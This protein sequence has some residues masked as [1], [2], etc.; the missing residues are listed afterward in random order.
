MLVHVPKRTPSSAR[1]YP[2]RLSD[3]TRERLFAKAERAG[4]SLAEALRV[5]GEQY[6]DA[7]IAAQD[8][9]STPLYHNTDT[10]LTEVRS[11]AAK[12]DRRFRD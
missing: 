2:L 9:P 8:S 10:L 11:L 1:N 4:I 5:G 6:L 7:L 3:E 12:I